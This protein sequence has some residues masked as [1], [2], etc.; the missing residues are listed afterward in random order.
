MIPLKSFTLC[1]SSAFSAFD[2][3]SEENHHSVIP[4]TIR[5]DFERPRPIVDPEAGLGIRA[6]PFEPLIQDR[7]LPKSGTISPLTTEE[8]EAWTQWREDMHFR[9]SHNP[10]YRVSSNGN[11]ES[12]RQL[13]YLQ[14]EMSR[15]QV[16]MNTLVLMEE[17]PQMRIKMLGFEAALHLEGSK[18]TESPD[19]A[20]EN[21]AFIN[22]DVSIE[23]ENLNFENA[24]HGG[25]ASKSL[26]ISDS[27]PDEIQLDGSSEQL[28]S[29]LDTTTSVVDGKTLESKHKTCCSN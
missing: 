26:N 16:R 3:V 23:N 20:A 29:C 1:P 6:S 22:C 4:G 14:S 25:W 2:D 9:S 19:S 10:P 28:S 5:Q 17:K 7:N 12:R 24:A 27:L 15:K 21:R 8:Y 13:P 11:N 18:N